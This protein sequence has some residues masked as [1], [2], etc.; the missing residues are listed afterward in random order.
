M[1]IYLDEQDGVTPITHQLLN[2]VLDLA[3]GYDL[4][5]QFVAGIEEFCNENNIKYHL[6]DEDV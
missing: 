4:E 1:T 5:D 2:F 6:E 3:Y